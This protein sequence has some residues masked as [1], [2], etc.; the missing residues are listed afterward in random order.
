MTSGYPIPI[1]EFKAWVS[2]HN[3]RGHEL[4]RCDDPRVK[5]RGLVC[6]ECQE[7]VKVLASDFDA[8]AELRTAPVTAA[9]CDPNDFKWKRGP[10]FD[11]DFSMTQ[12]WFH[13]D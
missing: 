3:G 5:A 4:L 12:N 7:W 13:H 6:L 8:D 1:A 2:D 10:V 11:D 9:K